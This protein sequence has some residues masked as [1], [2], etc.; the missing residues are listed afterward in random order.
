MDFASFHFSPKK[1]VS[2]HDRLLPEDRSPQRVPLSA[3]ANRDHFFNAQLYNSLINGIHPDATYLNEISSIKGGVQQNSSNQNSKN[4]FFL[5]RCKRPVKVIKLSDVPSD[6]YVHPIDWSKN[7][8][9][10]SR[11]KDIVF[12]TPTNQNQSESFTSHRFSH[13]KNPSALSFNRGKATQNNEV[14]LVGNSAGNIYQIDVETN[15]VISSH[16][17]PNLSSSFISVIKCMKNNLSIVGDHTGS[18]S[19]V[20]LRKGENITVAKKSATHRM[21]ICNI[22][23]NDNVDDSNDTNYKFASGGNDNVVKIWDVRNISRPFSTYRHHV[24]AVRGIAWN[25][26]KSNII[27]TGGGSNDR[28][29]RVWDINTGETLSAAQT[30]SQVCNLYWSSRYHMILSTHGFSQNTIGLWKG[31]DLQNVACFAIH[32]SRV[33]YMAVSPD[34]EYVLTAA[35]KDQTY[36]WN[37]FAKDNTYSQKMLFSLR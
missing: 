16:E 30:G 11:N 37:F 31:G 4:S 26:H 15:K 36:L 3:S 6:F 33:L 8:V 1:C 9:A 34:E 14:I 32:K 2:P 20:D 7:V 22:V 35:P 21:E 27:A 23:P 24:A 17:D 28:T 13:I 5:R 18:I 10:F 25:P 29:I 12:F 19:L